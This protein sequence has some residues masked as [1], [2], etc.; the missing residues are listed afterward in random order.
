MLDRCGG[1]RSYK[2]AR[3]VYMRLCADLQAQPVVLSQRQAGFLS[4]SSL[5]GYL[6][7]AMYM[8]PH[9]CEVTKHPP[10]SLSS[11]TPLS[12]PSTYFTHVQAVQYV[13]RSM[14]HSTSAHILKTEYMRVC[15]FVD[16][17]TDT[18]IHTS[19]CSAEHCS[20][21]QPRWLV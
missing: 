2:M 11:R 15:C 21:T 3:H 17:S 5:N 4:V 19:L 8:A 12:T 10:P 13:V 1:S 18:Y 20:G 16:I 14:S 6:H 7:L 9:M